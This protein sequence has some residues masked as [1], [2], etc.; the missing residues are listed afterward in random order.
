MWAVVKSGNSFGINLT[1]YLPGYEVP[2]ST[3]PTKEEAQEAA[4]YLEKAAREAQE[5]AY[6][7]ETLRMTGM[8]VAQLDVRLRD[9]KVPS[10][11]RTVRVSPPGYRNCKISGAYGE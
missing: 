8:T 7:K 10:G 11:H 6:E 9:V 3:H 5:A 2:V 1:S 4:S